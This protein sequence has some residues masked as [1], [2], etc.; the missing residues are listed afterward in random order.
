MASA[1][2]P[3]R[4]VGKKSKEIT[5]VRKSGKIGNS[6]RANRHP[7]PARN[8]RAEIIAEPGE[9]SK[10]VE[11]AAKANADE[12]WR[13]LGRELFRVPHRNEGERRDGETKRLDRVEMLRD[14]GEG[15]GAVKAADIADLDEKEQRGRSILE[16]GHDRLRRVPDQRAK[17][18]G[19][20]QRLERAREKHGRKSDCKDQRSAAN[21]D[22]L[23][24]RMCKTVDQEAEEDGAGDPGGIDGRRLVAQ[25]HAG[26]RDNE[27]SREPRPSAVLEIVFA[28]RGEGKHPVAHRQRN[29]DGGGH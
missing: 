16:A 26:D 15:D 4:I 11:N 18:D 8:D 3:P 17:L 6:R 12:H 5:G 22:R 13:N 7:R 9:F 27:C 20:E 1:S 23:R 10:V 19:A 24:V 2:A 29:G 14:L 25:Q 28:E 21:G